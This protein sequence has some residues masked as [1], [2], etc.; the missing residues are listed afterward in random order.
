MPK[1]TSEEKAF[2]KEYGGAPLDEE[3]LAHE[4]E[5][6]PGQLGEAAKLLNLARG[7]FE[8]ELE[9]IGFEHG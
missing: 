3:A 4:A 5:K 7:V 9:R 6:V 1:L 2:R 8:R